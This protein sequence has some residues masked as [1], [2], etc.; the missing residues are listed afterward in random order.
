MSTFRVRLTNGDIRTG[1]GNLDTFSQQQTS[2]TGAT[3]ASPI[4]ITTSVA[5]G[6]QSGRRLTVE[7]ISGNT[8]ANGDWIITVLSTTTFGLNGSSGNGVYTSSG[9]WKTDSVQRTMYAPGPRKINR[10]LRDGDTFI[11]CN[12]WKRFAYPTLPYGSAFIE[13]VSDDGS[14]YIDGEDNSF[15]LVTDFT[16]AALSLYASNTIDYLTTY[17]APANFAQITVAGHSVQCR[18]NGSNSAVF[19]IAAG[20]TQVFNKNDIVLNKLEFQNNTSG[21]SGATVEI[22]ASVSSLCQS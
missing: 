19:T 12:Y 8:A 11:D 10:K 18:I 7:N 5:H 21:A 13:V 2:I 15:P 6:L 17:G 20:T 22:V 4:V 3:N 1:G 16:I 14:S 9:D